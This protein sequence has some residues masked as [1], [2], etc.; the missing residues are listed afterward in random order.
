MSDTR[1]GDRTAFFVL[2]AAMGAAAALLMAPASGAHTRRARN[3]WAR[4]KRSS[5]VQKSPPSAGN[6]E[7]AP[8]KPPTSG[9][10]SSALAAFDQPSTPGGE[11]NSSIVP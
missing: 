3:C 9:M 10:E 8:R 1:A 4:P 6:R 5:V 2:G 11:P 7:G